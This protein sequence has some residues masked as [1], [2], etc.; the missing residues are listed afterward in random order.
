M[1]F[2]LQQELILLMQGL[3]AVE[4]NGRRETQ[5]KWLAAQ[6]SLYADGLHFQISFVENA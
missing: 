2:N 6:L 5:W 4:S 3:K 1:S